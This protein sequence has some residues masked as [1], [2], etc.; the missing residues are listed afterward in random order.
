M[1]FYLLPICRI[2]VALSAEERGMFRERIRYLEK[3]IKPGLTKITWASRGM[4]DVFIQDCRLHAGKVS[5]DWKISSSYDL[6]ISTT[7]I[8]SF[9]FYSASSS[10]LL[11]RGALDKARILCRS[12]TPK[13]HRQ[14]RVEDLP[15]VPTWRLERDSNPQPSSRKA[16][17]LPMSHLVP[18]SILLELHSGRMLYT[19]LSTDLIIIINRIIH[20]IIF[21]RTGRPYIWAHSV[22]CEIQ[23][24]KWTPETS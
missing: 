23:L 13:C 11:L 1:T 3:K 22:E 10:P 6:E 17:T 24:L 7:F 12:F 21:T 5:L 18:Q 2:V 14:L 19:S 9:H 8:H 15:K 4:S 20:I 16:S